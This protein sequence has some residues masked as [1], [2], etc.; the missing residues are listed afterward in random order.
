MEQY[1]QGKHEINKKIRS[2]FEAQI[3]DL[4]SSIEDSSASSIVRSVINDL[5]EQMQAEIDRRLK[6]LEVWKKG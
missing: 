1:V 3:Q 6:K 2:E 5:K 4:E